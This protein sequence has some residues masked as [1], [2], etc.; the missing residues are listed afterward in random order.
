MVIGG[1]DP[2]GGAG[3]QADIESAMAAGCHAVT[4]L[5]AATVQDSSSVH[6]FALMEPEWVLAQANA[7]MADF[8]VA[9]IKTGMMGSSANIEALANWYKAQHSNASPDTPLVVDPVLASNQGDELAADDLAPAYRA[10]LLPLATVATPN[11]IELMRLAPETETESE[12]DAANALL[13]L[14]CKNVLVTG[15]HEQTT[16][17]E[18]KLYDKTGIISR[19]SWPRLDHEYHGSGCTL[20]SAVAAQMALGETIKQAVTI[21]QGY[22]QQ[23]LSK[24][25][26]LGAGQWIPNRKV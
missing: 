3:L 21:A 19:L 22:T 14:G 12:E 9:A 20:A 17:V 4:V 18:N 24:S 26:H 2:S 10:H 11:T 7:I 1:L 5:T 23:S 25:D 8:D 13:A 16:D 6:D 15:G